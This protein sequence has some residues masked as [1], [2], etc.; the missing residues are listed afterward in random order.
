[1]EAILFWVE[2]R[3]NHA[4]DR[5]TGSMIKTAM[6][7]R[8]RYAAIL[9]PGFTV[10]DVRKRLFLSKPMP[11]DALISSSLRDGDYSLFE[12]MD[13][14]LATIGE[15]T[16]ESLMYA[17]RI[18][19]LCAEYTDALEAV[20]TV[21]RLLRHGGSERISLA[22]WRDFLRRCAVL[23]F[24]DFLRFIFEQHVI[25]QHLSV[26][27]RRFD[28]GSQRLRITI[29][30][31]GLTPLTASPLPLRVTPDRLATALSLMSDCGLIKQ[32][33]DWKYA[34]KR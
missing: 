30:E 14:I 6:Q 10:T 15:T 29:E 18:L 34:A 2:E 12:L 1:M 16:E 25:S 13:R 24:E 26:A 27:A 28:G 21:N 7:V 8:T 19:F 9:P 3:L 33:A 4:R 22:Y 31:E 11:L 32:T 5:E 23:S 17:L 20:E